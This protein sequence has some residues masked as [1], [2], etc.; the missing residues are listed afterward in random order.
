MKMDLRETHA[1]WCRL[2]SWERLVWM[3]MSTFRCDQ[4]RRLF[5]QLTCCRF[6]QWFLSFTESVS[7]LLQSYSHYRYHDATGGAF[8]PGALN[9][10]AQNWMGQHN[11]SDLSIAGRQHETSN[12]TDWNGILKKNSRF[13]GW[14]SNFINSWI[15]YISVISIATR[16]VLDGP[17]LEPRSG[18]RFF[19][20]LFRAC[21]VWL[22]GPP[23]LLFYGYRGFYL[24]I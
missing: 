3:R 12:I 7:L 20:I 21:P 19:F 2:H 17:E 1:D 22:W 13:K 8:A 4:K 10:G 14:K 16:Y 23:S 11:L 6:L 15:L 24:G 9:L 5:S 18:M